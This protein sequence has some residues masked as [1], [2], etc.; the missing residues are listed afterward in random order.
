MQCAVIRDAIHV[1][2]YNNSTRHN[3]SAPR[4]V[5]LSG[6]VPSATCRAAAATDA[7]GRPRKTCHI[8]KLPYKCHI[9]KAPYKEGAV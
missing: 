9:R 7:M 4:D 3:N 2:G 6:E 8:R 1:A 5:Y